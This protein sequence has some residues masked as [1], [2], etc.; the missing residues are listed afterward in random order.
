MLVT[1]LE[2]VLTNPNSYFVNLKFNLGK[3]R[4]KKML[5][6]LENLKY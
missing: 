4:L 2:S 5:K 1:F 6:D 3:N